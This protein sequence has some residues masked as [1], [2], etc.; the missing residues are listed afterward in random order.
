[1]LLLL[2]ENSGEVL[3]KQELLEHLWPGSIVEEAN[4]SQTIYLL[5]RALG[6]GA[7]GQQ[8][9]ETIPKRG[10][11]FVAPVEQFVEEASREPERSSAPKPVAVEKSSRK[12]L[13]ITLGGVILLASLLFLFIWFP[14]QEAK[15]AETAPIKSLAV[16]P[17]K[18]IN[19]DGDNYLGLGMA[20]V[21][22]TRLSELNQIVVQ[23]IGTV[24]KYDSPD[25]HPF[26]A[27][28]ELKVDAVLEGTFQKVNDRLRVTLRLDDIRKGRTIWSGQLDER[29]TDIFH[30]QD[31]ISDQVVNALSLNLSREKRAAMLR[32]YTANNEAY[33]LYMKGRFWWSKRTVVSLRKAVGYFEQAISLSPDYALAYAGLADCYNLLSILED[34]PPQEAFPKAKAAAL[35]AL[36][37]DD[38]LAE[39]HAALG[40]TKWVYDW[41]WT[42]SEGEFKI[43]IG[44]S[45]SYATAYD[46][47]GVCL[48]QTG[49][50]DEALKQLKQAQQLDPLSLVI[51]VHIGWVY[52]YSGKYDL[53][54][55]QY[56]KA[57]E[58]DPSYVW[59]RA[60]LSQAYEQKKMYAEAIAELKQVIAA[61]SV[62]HRH[63]AGLA[64]IY[65]LNGSRQEAKA[66][67]EDLLQ[68]EKQHYVSP[69][70]IA[71]VYA[72]LAEKEQAFNWLN[73]GAEKRA[74][75][76][77][78][79][80]FDPRF[81]NLRSD[82][83]FTAI[84]NRINQIPQTSPT[85]SL[86][87]SGTR[88]EL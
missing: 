2:V 54:I 84:I 56:Q 88:S 47:Y 42:E 61:S 53:A 80:Q 3:E 52:Y 50:F 22:I 51:Q 40:W 83:R 17:F 28:Q 72:G 6:E 66:L 10:Y 76:M 36:Q 74:G 4:L 78:R 59:A 18:Q 23:P 19:T 43:A 57:L 81:K 27:G 48:A 64:H 21:L 26:L 33:E 44:L 71:L 62:V 5:R 11:R 85:I 60:H 69:Y 37:I 12:P 35:K 24:R 41:D 68:R 15:K 25:A 77:V 82:S 29:F 39:A 16:L 63:L 7:S 70:S 1:M 75:R 49:R 38:T 34:I 13:W 45:P 9:V 30:V 73:K 79:L 31:S 20:D 86:A 67:L 65:T 14:R 55:E 87:N 8:F 58:M 32:H 46:G